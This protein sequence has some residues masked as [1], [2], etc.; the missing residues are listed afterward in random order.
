MGKLIVWPWATWKI[1]RGRG[2]DW[3]HYW[4]RYVE[5]TFVIWLHHHQKLRDFLH[6]LSSIHQSIQ[7]TI[8]TESE[9]HLPFLDIDIYRRPDDILGNKVYCYPIYT[10]LYLNAKSHHHSSNIQVVLPLRYTE[11]ELF[12]MKTACRLS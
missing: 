10:I 6:N 5:N 3:P 11:P 2:L 12:V 7:F 4:F 8:E 1:T 9:G